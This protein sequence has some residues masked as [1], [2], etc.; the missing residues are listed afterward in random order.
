M[1]MGIGG[2]GSSATGSFTHT[3]VFLKTAILAGV[4]G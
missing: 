2:I 1:E 3:Y 4:G